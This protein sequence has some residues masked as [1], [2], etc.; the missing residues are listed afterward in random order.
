MYKDVDNHKREAFKELINFNIIGTD[1]LH[2]TY[3]HI[4][5]FKFILTF[6]EFDVI[7]VDRKG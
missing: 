7:A 3:F 6:P 4:I 5:A 1:F 2:S